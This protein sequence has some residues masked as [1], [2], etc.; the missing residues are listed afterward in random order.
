MSC[1]YNQNHSTD[2]FDRYFKD[3]LNASEEIFVLKEIKKKL[4]DVQNEA[5][6]SCHVDNT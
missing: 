6:C 5:D 1:E 2:Y 4:A 3:T